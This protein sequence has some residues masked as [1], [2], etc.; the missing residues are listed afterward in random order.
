MNITKVGLYNEL[1]F[2]YGLVSVNTKAQKD[3]YW[4]PFSASVNEHRSSVSFLLWDFCWNCLSVLPGGIILLFIFLLHY[5]HSAWLKTLRHYPKCCLWVTVAHGSIAIDFPMTYQLCHNNILL[6]DGHDP[7]LS[8]SS[9]PHLRE[10]LMEPCLYYSILSMSERCLAELDSNATMK[11]GQLDLAPLCGQ[12]HRAS[13][14]AGAPFPSKKRATSWSEEHSRPEETSIS[15]MNAVLS[16]KMAEIKSAFH[17][18]FGFVFVDVTAHPSPQDVF[19]GVSAVGSS[20][21]SVQSSGQAQ[22]PSCPIC[23]DKRKALFQMVTSFA[24]PPCKDCDG[25]FNCRI[26]PTWTVLKDC[27]YV[28]IYGWGGF[29]QGESCSGNRAACRSLGGISWWD[30][31]R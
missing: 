2:Q 31:T 30:S 3:C 29:H 10:A 28:S 23:P 9:I 5:H 6:D 19:T 14:A 16:S 26:W 11:L 15:N 27:S 22:S 21:G 18:C 12:K 24:M 8:R 13:A 1:K 7:C 4:S 17:T 25:I 20:G